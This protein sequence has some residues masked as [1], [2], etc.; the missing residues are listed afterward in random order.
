MITIYDIAK[1]LNVSH[2]TVS[3]ALRNNPAIAASTRE[4]VQKIAAKLNYRP[5]LLARGLTG[6]ATRT[7]GVV[8]TL[9]NP[10]EMAKRMATRAQQHEWVAYTADTMKEKGI[11]Q[12]VLADFVSRGVDAAV[13][14]LGHQIPLS[15]EL[16]EYLNRFRAAVIVTPSPRNTQLD[17]VVHDRFGAIRS[18]VEHFAKSG[19]KRPGI[20]VPVA[21]SQPKIDV[22]LEEFRKY[23][24]YPEGR[25]VIDVRMKDVGNERFL[26]VLKTICEENSSPFDCLFCSSDELA[27]IVISYLKSKGLDVPRDIAVAGFN[28][29]KTS[30]FMIPPMASVVRKDR[31]VADTIE[32]LLFSRLENPEL[33]PRQE[34]VAMEFVWRESAG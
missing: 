8:W 11:I 9:S 6:G 21:E 26:E 29:N 34:T 15:P 24:I 3:R 7:L 27:M 5:N 13:V 30:Q 14:E 12:R 32:R 10:G 33:P 16:E 31:E 17:Q 19:R 2:A 28:D 25:S 1:K 18:I 23:G 4:K 22:Y 20:L